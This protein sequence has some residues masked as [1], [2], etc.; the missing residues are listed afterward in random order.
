[1]SSFIKTKSGFVIPSN[2]GVHCFYCPAII[3]KDREAAGRLFLMNGKPAC[4][5]C[6]ILAKSKVSS[7]IRRDSNLYKQD[8][9]NKNEHSQ[10]IANEKVI[11]IASKTQEATRTKKN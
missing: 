9:Q 10:Q 2:S 5:R 4:A 1:M 7:Q 11:D 3:Y 6:R 8:L